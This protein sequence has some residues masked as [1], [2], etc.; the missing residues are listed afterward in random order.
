MWN[1]KN[2]SFNNNSNNINYD[3]S[4]IIILSINNNIGCFTTTQ[5]VTR[6]REIGGVVSGELVVQCSGPGCCLSGQSSGL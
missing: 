4:I 5:H 3:N 1:K 6:S 2:G